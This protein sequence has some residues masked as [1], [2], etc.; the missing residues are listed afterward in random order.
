MAQEFWPLARRDEGS[1]HRFKNRRQVAS[2]T[3]LCP[4]E[5]SI[6]EK[7]KQGAI[8]K[9]GNPR[10]RHQM[11]ETVWR[12]QIWQ[13]TYPPLKKISG[14]YPC[15]RG[16]GS[17]PYTRGVGGG[18][19]GRSDLSRFHWPALMR[20]NRSPAQAASPR[21]WRSGS[22]NHV[23]EWRNQLPIE[24]HSARGDIS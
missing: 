8:S 2:C 21:A 23:Q 1:K 9:H 16:H 13:P 18:K 11:V 24:A 19:G 5:H 3:G 20:S 12:M 14:R 6:G 17:V 10:V 22:A 15:F 4:S 7:R